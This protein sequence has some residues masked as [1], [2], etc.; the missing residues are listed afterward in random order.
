MTRRW[1]KLVRSTVAAL[2][3]VVVTLGSAAGQGLEDGRLGDGRVLPAG[4]GVQGLQT[5]QSLPSQSPPSGPGKAALPSG[6]KDQTASILTQPSNEGVRSANQ[7]LQNE[8]GFISFDTVMIGCTAGAAAGALSVAMP[9]VTAAS[10]GIGLPFSAT[11]V[12]STAAVGCTVGVIS[13]VVAIASALGLSFL[14][15][16]WQKEATQQQIAKPAKP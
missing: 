10:T 14:D 6:G 16:K 13:G 3:M 12:A 1:T 11:L 4:Q 15:Y 2:A 8:E 5:I 9:A 7:I